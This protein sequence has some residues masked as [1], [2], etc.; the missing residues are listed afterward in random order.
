M[1]RR[2]DTWSEEGTF[3]VTY[4][5]C[6]G[7]Q[8][9]VHISWLLPQDSQ[10]ISLPWH[11]TSST[12]LGCLTERDTASVCVCVCVCC[13]G[14]QTSTHQHLLQTADPQGPPAIQVSCLTLLTCCMIPWINTSYIFTRLPWTPCISARN[15]ALRLDFILLSCSCVDR[16]SVLHNVDSLFT[17]PPDN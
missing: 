8:S 7:T 13:K 6:T 1:R 14:A 15:S 5:G 16:K 12:A 11:G 9:S 17:V 4:P 3:Y 2:R 10:I